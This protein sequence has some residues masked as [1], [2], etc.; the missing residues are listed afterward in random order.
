MLFEKFKK[1]IQK[2]KIIQK[3]DKIVIAISGGPDSVVMTHL[4]FRL[5]K[6][7]DL[8]L[9]GVHLDHCTRD[10]Q[11]R[12]D[13]LF[14]KN[15]LDKHSIKSF[16]FKKNVEQ[17]A[18][19]LK[20]SFE[21]A[22]RKVRY[23]KFYE[24]LDKV[25]G[26]KIAI[27]QNMNDQGETVLFRLFRGT[28]LDGLTGIDFKRDGKIIRP[29][30][31]IKRKDI[32]KYY[33]KENL[34]VAIDHTNKERIYARNKIRLDIIPYIKKHF[35]ENITESLF[36]TADLLTADK[37]L[38]D[39]IIKDFY[40]NKVKFE[41]DKY[42]LSINE[43]NDQL[44]A[45]KFRLIRKLIFELTGSLKNVSYE[46]VKGVISLANKNQTGKYKLIKNIKFLVEYDKLK[47][48]KLKESRSDIDRKKLRTQIIKEIDKINFNSKKSILYIDKDKIN[49]K[50]FMRNRLPGDS[51]KPLGMK[52]TKKLK[53]Y[54]IDEK[55]SRKERDKIK[56]VCDDKNIIWIVG[57]RMD[58]RYKITSDTKKALMLKYE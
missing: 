51:F 49:G 47:V 44:K 37:K 33:K 36:K 28:G 3:G 25:N 45:L 55:I 7:Y 9:F 30:L 39:K 34:E 31:N 17:M 53:D 24:V 6:I 58:R 43:F 11:S 2:R 22:G 12:K 13:A 27:G 15:F 40:E 52:G 42:L 16:M 19:D 35:N 57:Y 56:L 29:I 14:V 10:G 50:I 21:Q 5:K 38:I 20:I 32:E 18:K 1:S 26:D 48:Y 4:L 46:M 8:E 23:K 54:F 41:D